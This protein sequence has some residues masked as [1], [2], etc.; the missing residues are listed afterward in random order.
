MSKALFAEYVSCKK[1]NK[2]FRGLGLEHMNS[3]R[4]VLPTQLSSSTLRCSQFQV[5]C[6]IVF[7][8]PSYHVFR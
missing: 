2:P 7:F 8:S 6:L 3:S 1:R 5:I 4:P